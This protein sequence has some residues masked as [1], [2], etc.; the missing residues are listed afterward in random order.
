MGAR[1]HGL[2]ALRGS[3][4]LIVLL[5]HATD[6][7]LGRGM[8][9][10][11]FFALSGF[12]MARSYEAK[13]RDGLTPQK[14]IERRYSRLIPALFIGMLIGAAY[15]LSIGMPWGY[16]LFSF[17]LSTMMMPSI[18][19]GD[20][21]YV[22]NQPVWSLHFEI[23]MNLVH[24]LALRRISTGWLGALLIPLLIYA[25]VCVTRYGVIGGALTDYYLPALPLAFTAY[26]SGILV[27]RTGFAP[28]IPGAIYIVPAL[29]IMSGQ[30]AP[31]AVRA[32]VALLA[33]PILI[34]AATNLKTSKVGS[35]LGAISYPLYCTHVPILDML[36]KSVWSVG[37]CLI[38]AT[39]IGLVFEPT[40]RPARD[41][42]LRPLQALKT[43]PTS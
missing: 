34:G 7:W 39:F 3:A 28:K 26:I 15:G 18:P 11:L 21:L 13:M 27:F 32:V 19:F 16:V 23:V 37:L 5:A 20:R 29:I 42:M 14:F 6:L 33:L 1:L 9:V 35:F 43:A 31:F 38:V 22:L 4:A 41:R 10:M 30:Y 24:A 25:A 8:A 12:V 40:L 36:G 17:G 2:D